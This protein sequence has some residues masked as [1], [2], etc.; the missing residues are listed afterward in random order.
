MD[1][2]IKIKKQIKK[3]HPVFV[4]QD[5]HKKKRLS[6]SWRRP[7]GHHSKMREMRGGHPPL[8]KPGYR[9]PKELRNK[10]DG[11]DIVIVHN[12]DELKNVDP[13]KQFVVVSKVGLKKKAEILKECNKKKIKVLNLNADKVLKKVEE[14]LKSKEEKEKKKS[15]EKITKEEKKT[16]E[17]EELSVEEKEKKEKEEKDKILIKAR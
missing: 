8:V 17:K 16:K 2:L 11:F 15:E 9:T 10:I 13:K 14:K 4:R 5:F 6:E 7:K 3:N 12:V 1:D